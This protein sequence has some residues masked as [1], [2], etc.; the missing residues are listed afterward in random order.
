MP[1]LTIETW[2]TQILQSSGTTARQRGELSLEGMR[3]F[4]PRQE[5]EPELT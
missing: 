4:R 5:S 1:V 3:M 2:R